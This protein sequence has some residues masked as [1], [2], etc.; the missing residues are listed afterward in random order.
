[1]R[2]AETED[3]TQEISFESHFQA[4]LKFEHR[5]CRSRNFEKPKRNS[6]EIGLCYAHWPP[7]RML[8]CGVAQVIEYEDEVISRLSS[9]EHAA[10]RVVR[11]QMKGL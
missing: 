2:N 3:I 4:Y 1:M 10:R 9:P 5:T 11:P 8:K 7:L 6:K